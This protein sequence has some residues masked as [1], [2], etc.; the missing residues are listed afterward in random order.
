MAADIPAKAVSAP[1]PIYN[2]TGFYVGVNGGYGFGNRSATFNPDEILS[3]ASCTALP[4]IGGTCP[5]PTS[6]DSKGGIA[7]LQ[8]GFNWQFDRRWL[9]G[10]EADFDYS[11]IHGSG[12][13]NFL[14]FSNPLFGAVDDPRATFRTT[15][16][17]N[18]F[19]TVRGRLGF[20]PTQRALLYAT[21][22]LAY[23]RIGETVALD[24]PHNGNLFGGAGHLGF[25]CAPFV[26]GATSQN[27][28]CFDGSSTRTAFGYTAG[29]GME[30]AWG[31]VS[32]K[33]EYLYLNFGSGD[34]VVGTATATIG[35]IG[36]G[37]ASFAAGYN[38]SDYHIFRVGVNVLVGPD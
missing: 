18:W 16:E 29:A 17:L 28:D 36:F 7:G 24:T 32:V 34:S 3:D 23:G 26:A 15:S 22:G 5:S 35:G 30:V 6:F 10:L 9:A 13:S 27:I 8:S 33:A 20:L 25:G 4:V 12:A 37:P 21:G 14:M 11:N 1:A 38:K 19:G 2:W 31:N